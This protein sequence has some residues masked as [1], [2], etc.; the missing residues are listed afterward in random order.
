LSL[1]S[2]FAPSTPKFLHVT[3]EQVQEGELKE[4]N[5]VLKTTEQEPIAPI[6]SFQFSPKSQTKTT[7][8][9][10]A[11]KTDSAAKTPTFSFAGTEIP[12]KHVQEVAPTTK[13]E[14]KTVEGEKK[15][16]E[17]MDVDPPAKTQRQTPKKT[18]TEKKPPKSPSSPYTP[19]GSSS[20]T[21]RPLPS[22]S[23]RPSP[24]LSP[25]SSAPF[26]KIDAVLQKSKDSLSNQ[27]KQQKFQKIQQFRKNLPIFSVKDILMKEI[28]ENYSLIVV[29][30]TGTRFFGDFFCGGFWY[31]ESWLTPSSFF[32]TL[33]IP[34]KIYFRF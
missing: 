23:P 28:K 3:N 34:R 19:P 8:V 33:E 21:S 2:K 4:E 22:T 12:V 30:E 17:K 14:E 31:F 13:N 25:S 10:S 5:D 7:D 9:N 15:N 29:G 1:T 27:T 18:P 32:L 24:S 11:V 16:S 26:S 6:K 20:S